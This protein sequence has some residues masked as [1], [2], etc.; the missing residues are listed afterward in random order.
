MRKEVSPY[1]F[2]TQFIEAQEYSLKGSFWALVD[3]AAAH[4]K[5][6]RRSNQWIQL[7]D[8]QLFEESGSWLPWRFVTYTF[9]SKDQF[10]HFKNFPLMY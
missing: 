9:N 6:W 7:L 8:G 2:D 4:L 10:K 3:E 5:K 1:N